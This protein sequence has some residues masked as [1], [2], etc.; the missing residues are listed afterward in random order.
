MRTWTLV[1]LLSTWATT[2][3]AGAIGYA[4]A[5]SYFKQ[6]SRPTLYQPLNLLDGRDATA[7]CSASPDPLDEALTF[8]FTGPVQVEEVRISNGNNFDANTWDTFSRARKLL[9]RSDE[10]SQTLMLEDL[11]GLQAVKLE[12][13]MKGARFR[14]E[15]LDSYPSDDL[16]KPM[17]LTD[18]VFY[19]EGKP[20][21]GPW[22]ATRLKYDRASAPLLGTWFA[23]HDRSPDRFWSFNFDGTF[24]YTFE[25]YDGLS[26]APRTLDGRYEATSS[27][28][29]LEI[30]GKRHALAVSRLPRKGGGF[31]L[32][33]DGEL[34]AELKGS[35]RSVR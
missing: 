22:L 18:V 6:D 26:G 29:T 2:A 24:H 13:P 8:G 3:A 15:I 4:Q 10:G 14:L 21:N 1:S 5:T 23:G 33:L 25:P 28:L 9:L 35:W 16:D 12:P 17:C 32:K 11:R 7:W 34:P 27:R 20:L 31:E 30:K 19:S